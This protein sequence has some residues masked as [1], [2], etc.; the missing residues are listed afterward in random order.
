[1]C[2]AQVRG[3][4]MRGAVVLLALVLLVLAVPAARAGGSFTDDEG[5][6]L[7]TGAPTP[8]A[9]NPQTDAVDLVALD[10]LEEDNDFTL[11]VKVK[12]L[13]Q[14]G[15]SMSSYSVDMTWMDATFRVFVSRSRID[16]TA[17]PLFRASLQAIEGGEASEI[18]ELEVTSDHQ[19]TISVRLPKVNIISLQGHAP[20][21]GSELTGVVVRAEMP[22]GFGPAA[23][24]AVDAMPDTGAG[25]IEYEKGGSANG[26][27]VLE[28]PDPVRISNGGAT[29]FVFQ[30]HL[31][32]QGTADDTATLAIEDLPE[33][34][35]AT[36]VP[37]QQVPAGEE[38]P[39]FVVVTIPF[40]HAH[41]GF[42]NFSLTAT[43]QSN[44]DVEASIR[45]GVLHTPVPM[46]AGHHSEL[47]LHARPA[48]TGALGTTFGGT[49][50]TMNTLGER[51]SDEVEYAAP[52][53]AAA[54]GPQ[55]GPITWNVPLGP[56]LAMGLDAD[57]NRTGEI[58]AS[59]LGRMSG[60]ATLE[61][62]VLLVKGETEIAAMM[63]STP[64]QLKLDLQTPTPFTIPLTPTPESDYVAYVP[65]Q[66]LVL[67]LT[68]TPATA[69][70]CCG[71]TDQAPGLTVDDFRMALPLNEYA[72]MPQWDAGIASSVALIAD[73]PL[74][75]EGR[76]GTVLAYT[77]TL[78]NQLDVEDEID[79][80]IAGTHASLA[81]LAPTQTVKLAAK[82]SRTMMLAVAIPA[83]ADNDEHLEVLLVA[84]SQS[85]ASNIAIGRTMTVVQKGSATADEK[86]KLDAALD[87][88]KDTPGPTLAA[89]LIAIGLIALRRRRA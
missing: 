12:S 55:D 16:P 49:K 2:P 60:E 23:A 21:F 77:F 1:M 30:G 54:F 15:G 86:A 45:Y 36:T 4:D 80:G 26:H 61:A 87:E 31:Q 67:R 35:Q 48:D 68:L 84:R 25:V 85:D 18:S 22:V 39:V 46:P 9:P 82:A 28:A 64:V 7:V 17:E 63:T 8:L 10:V 43:S 71:P 72:D 74:Q 3:A 66:N 41:G 57:L 73:G 32:N 56:N 76:P 24:S 89:T 5:D 51:A 53:T 78:T 59:I 58:A 11:N 65:G 81:T 62:V 13:T 44:P 20:V 6:V 38:R 29:T 69:A 40:A 50:N 33:A 88:G 70:P 83:A 14:Q 75:R 47:Y 34:W 19:A 52:D 27:F 42:S 37:L 79:L